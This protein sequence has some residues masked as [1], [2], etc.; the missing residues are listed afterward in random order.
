MWSESECERLC[1]H[2]ISFLLSLTFIAPGCV[3]LNRTHTLVESLHLVSFINIC[4]WI[5]FCITAPLLGS[6]TRLRDR[7]RGLD[8]QGELRP[9][10]FEAVRACDQDASWVPSFGGFSRYV[11]QAFRPRGRPKTRWKNNE[12]H[13]ISEH[14][15]F[16]TVGAGKRCWIG[17]RKS[18]P[19]EC[20]CL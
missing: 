1:L 7:M 2:L 10:P 11:C 17:G 4:L 18:F 19:F 16:A 6:L 15:G 5:F 3:C 12:S 9:E 13:L 14:L 8:V 20:E